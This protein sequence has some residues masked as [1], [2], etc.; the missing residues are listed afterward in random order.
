VVI[1]WAVVAIAFATGGL[2]CGMGW[3]VA[4][5]YASRRDAKREG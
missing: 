2:G 5:W 3:T 1:W 4:L